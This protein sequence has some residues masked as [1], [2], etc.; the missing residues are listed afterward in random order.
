MKLIVQIPCFN[1]AETLRQTLADIPRQIA[2]VDQV[3]VLVVDDGSTDGTAELARELGID[4]VVRHKANMGLARSFRTG[5]E[6]GLALGADIIVNTDGDNQYAGAD[7]PRLIA[8]IL[9]GEADIVVG[10]RQTAKVAHFSWGK[11]LLQA[12]GSFVVRQLSHTDVPDAVSGFRAIS[13][14]AALHLN[15]VSSFSYTIEMLIQAGRKQMAIVAVPVGT[16]AKTRKSR[17]FKSIPGFI[18]HSLVTMV[19]MYSMYRPLRL[20]FYLGMTLSA[21]GALPILRFV[22]LYMTGDGEGHIQS[23]VLGGVLVVIGFMTL[24]IGLVADLVNFNRQLIEMTLEK[25]RRLEL[26][27]QAES[28]RTPARAAVTEQMAEVEQLARDWQLEPQK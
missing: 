4:H 14:E 8:P 26:A 1:E 15:I 21:A 5:I 18:R 6:A 19:R 12:L 13:R 23:L 27:Q 28:P 11:K 2:D 16:N 24:L 3:E 17:L 9:A 22:Y 25:V 20:F 10:D 7:I